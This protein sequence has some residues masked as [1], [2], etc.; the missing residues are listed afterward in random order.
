MFKGIRSGCPSDDEGRLEPHQAWQ[1]FAG[2]RVIGDVH[3][4]ADA[5]AAL[6]DEGRSQNLFIVQLGDLVDRGP[7]SVGALRVALDLLERADGCFLRSNHDDKLKRA[8]RGNPVTADRYLQQTLDAIAGMP[9]HESL[10]PR[11][12]QALEN[13]P[14]W[15]RAGQYLMVHGAF[16]PAMLTAIGPEVVAPPSAAKLCRH[17]ALY[18]EKEPGNE[19]RLYHWVNTVP[20][21]VTVLIGHDVIATDRIAERRGILGGRI[22]FCDT[23]AGHGGELSCVDLPNSMPSVLRQ[24]A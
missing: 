16:H 7:D 5:F 2:I 17:M 19:A 9:N 11:I 14:F 18:G 12:Y 6:V 1:R 21:D 15:L 8:L 4:Q 10:F 22:L 3:G 13:A 24:R 23:G 20:P